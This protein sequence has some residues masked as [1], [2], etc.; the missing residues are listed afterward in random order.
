LKRVSEYLKL[1]RVKHYIKNTLIFVPLLFSR[2]F[3][4]RQN[5]ITCLYGFVCFSLCCSAV[6]S[7]NDIKDVEKDRKHTTKSKRPLAAGAISKRSAVITAI[8][9]LLCIIAVIAI[10]GIYRNSVEAICILVLYFLLNIAYSFGLKNIPILDI[11]IIASGFILR[12]IFGG[13]IIHVAIS[14]W[15]YLVISTGAF[16]L[17]FGKR[18]NEISAQKN[19][20]RVVSKVYSYNFLDKNMYVSQGLAIVFY[21]LWSIDPETVARF[22]SS[23]FIYTI[24]LVFIILLKY[25]LSVET[26]ADGD[27]TIIMFHD[28]VLFGLILLYILI[29]VVIVIMGNRL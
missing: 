4:E 21:S 22:H 25:S 7:I 20:T 26:D 29:A 6:Y 11:A 24:P 27:P 14:F 9:L 18:R 16:Y 8:V 19:E 2:T 5:I 13:L 17:G 1:L 28:K 23:A 10:S 12:I 3:V 15:L